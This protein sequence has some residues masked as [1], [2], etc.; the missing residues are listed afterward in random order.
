MTLLFFVLVGVAQ[1]TET[2]Q[3]LSAWTTVT[4]QGCW[5]PNGQTVVATCQSSALRSAAQWDAAQPW[6]M[7]WKQRAEPAS[8]HNRYWASGGWWVS[9]GG[10]IADYATA[11]QSRGVSGLPPGPQT[12]FIGDWYS[13]PYTSYVAG[14]WRTWRVEWDPVNKRTLVFLDGARVGRYKQ[15]RPNGP[16]R[17]RLECSSVGENTPDDGSAA[18]CEFGPITVTG[19]QL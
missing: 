4:Q 9:E 6:S 12:G 15:A 7:A 11:V 14:T 3:N 17:A 1:L 10:V 2:W 19:V 16:M 18:R 5:Q 8:T 13:D